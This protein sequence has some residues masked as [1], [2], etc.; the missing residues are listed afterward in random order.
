MNDQP[1]VPLTEQVEN[2]SIYYEEKNKTW[3]LFTNHIGIDKD[4]T[5]Y[6]DAIWVYW[7]KN[8]Y[9]W[10]IKNKAIVLDS[11]NCTWSKGAIGMPSVIK[12]GNK[13]A[14]LYDAYEGYSTYHMRRNIGLAWISLPIKISDR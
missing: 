6:T 1:I 12:V 10:D 7:S 3:Y 11:L 2:S 9:N 8:I 4:K 13:L 5:E 14:V